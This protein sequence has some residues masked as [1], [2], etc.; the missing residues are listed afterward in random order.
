MLV[1]RR[2]GRI[3]RGGSPALALLVALTLVACG[4]SEGSVT[5]AGSASPSAAAPESPSESPGDS[6]STEPLESPSVDPT[7]EPT[8]EPTDQPSGS[9]GTEPTPTAGG[10]GACL[11]STDTRD[12]FASFAQS[13][14]W[15]VYCAVL[16]KGWSVEKG[17]Y[18]LKNG[19]RLTITYRRRADSARVVLDEGTVCADTSPCVP[20]GTS[21]G[22]APFGDRQADLSSTGVGLAAV[23]DASEN[24]AWLLTGSGLTE[25]EFRAIAA[26]LHLLDQ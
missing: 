3:A 23:V 4:L 12:F 15:P 19:G 18:R 10:T 22:S 1:L 2:P 8:D 6:P 11:G 14:P 17:T 13:V 25:K 9:P 24:P 21:L 5:P 20:A 16:P 26:N 7:D